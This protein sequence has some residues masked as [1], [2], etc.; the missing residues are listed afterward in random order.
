MLCSTVRVKFHLHDG[1]RKSP[2]LAASRLCQANDITTLESPGDRFDLDSGWLG[3]LHQR[4]SAAELLAHPEGF[5]GGLPETPKLQGFKELKGCRR[6]SACFG[7]MASPLAGCTA[8]QSDGISD[9]GN[10]HELCQTL[11]HVRHGCSEDSPRT[12]Q[13][14]QN[15]STLVSIARPLLSTLCFG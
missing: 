15:A 10:T 7:S 2:S 8:C 13:F 6:N 11:S 12:P 14:C 1:Q 4:D 5:K 9:F 3:P